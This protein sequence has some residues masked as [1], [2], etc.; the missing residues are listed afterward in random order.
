MFMEAKHI[1]LNF[2]QFSDNFQQLSGNKHTTTN[3]NLCLTK[4]GRSDPVFGYQVVS[5]P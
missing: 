1:L 3:E 5:E 4:A 2:I